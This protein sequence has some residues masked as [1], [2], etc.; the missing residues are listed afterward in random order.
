MK[1]K[2][3]LFDKQL[4]KNYRASLAVVSLIFSFVLIGLDGRTYSGNVDAWPHLY[5]F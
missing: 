3:K 2:V 4:L 5:E 1:T